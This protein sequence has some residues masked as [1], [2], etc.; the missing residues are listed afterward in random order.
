MQWLKSLSERRDLS[1]NDT[2]YFICIW[3]REVHELKNVGEHEIQQSSGNTA[4]R[5]MS[6]LGSE[7][8]HT[9]PHNPINRLMPL[10][11]QPINRLFS[12]TVMTL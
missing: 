6:G 12:N 9:N 8:G 4:A 10:H 3:Y 2:L 1:K 11:T 5:V 7:V